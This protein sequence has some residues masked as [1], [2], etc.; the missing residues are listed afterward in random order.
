MNKGGQN[1]CDICK[2]KDKASGCFG[3]AL[4][5]SSTYGE[6]GN[7]DCMLNYECGCLMGFDDVCKASTCYRAD[8]LDYSCNECIHRTTKKDEGGFEMFW[9][10][11]KDEEIA[12]FDDACDDFE[13]D[14]A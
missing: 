13:E 8:A 9:C 4:D 5:Y 3:C 10:D 6:C 1:P 7:D 14:D 11:L 12:L 2:A